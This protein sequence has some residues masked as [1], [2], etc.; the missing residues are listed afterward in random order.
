[1]LSRKSIIVWLEI[2]NVNLSRFSTIKDVKLTYST[3]H[4]KLI[5]VFDYKEFESFRSSTY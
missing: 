5:A 2:P 1:M 4:T 3:K